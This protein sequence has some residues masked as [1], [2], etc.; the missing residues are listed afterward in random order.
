MTCRPRLVW[1]VIVTGLTALGIAAGAAGAT[2]QSPRATMAQTYPPLAPY[3]GVP[4]L[5]YHGVVTSGAT[6][7]A[8]TAEQFSSQMAMLSQ[9]GFHAITVA[10]YVAWLSGSGRLPVRPIL[11]TFDDGR[12]DSWRGAEPA[13][14]RYHLH[15]VMFTIVGR[16][17]TERFF[18]SW[19]QLREMAASGR[20]DVQFHADR[21]HVL[22]RTDAR[23]DLGPWYA[24]E[25]TGETF[26][27]Y[28]RRVTS[29]V[30]AGVAAM[31]AQIPGFR[32][33]AMALPY[34]S[35]GQ[36]V[37]NDARIPQFLGPWLA[38]RFPAVFTGDP[39]QFSTRQMP[40]Y[41]LGRLVVTSGLTAARMYSWLAALARPG[42][43]PAPLCAAHLT[44]T[45]G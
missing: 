14:N 44:Y 21:G 15:A 3:S 30:L 36:C 29:D 33:L 22:I 35:Y 8:V 34:G 37:T 41:R 42:A 11:I 19:R 1:A 10:Q 32:P 26:T 40:R 38:A 27:A 16:V 7:E 2:P 23:G 4:V 28:Q 24:N 12:L 17:G 20:W 6:G 43:K 13:L 31:R 18:L 39:E 9:A 25:L 5:N 45:G